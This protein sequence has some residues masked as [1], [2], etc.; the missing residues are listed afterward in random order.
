VNEV[1]S[2]TRRVVLRTPP[3][4]GISDQCLMVP[5]GA[6]DVEV[7]RW[8]AQCLDAASLE[9]LRR[10]IVDAAHAEALR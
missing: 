8:A 3:P 9:E 1:R 2:I 7:L 4:D 5:A 10:R 6:T